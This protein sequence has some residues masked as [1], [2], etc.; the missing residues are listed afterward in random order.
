[1]NSTPLKG[2]I[3]PLVTPF[4]EEEKIDKVSL[5][6]LVNYMITQEPDYLMA[7][8]LTG[9]GP[10]LNEHETLEVWDEIFTATNNRVAVIPAIISTRTKTAITL[11]KAAYAL[12]APAIMVA[13]IVPELYAARSESDVYQFYSDIA[14]ATP[15]PLILFNYPSLTSVDLTPDF[16]KRLS[17]IENIAYIKESTGD[18]RRVHAIQ[19]LCSS[20]F[21]V[22]CGNPNAAFES[23]ALGCDTWITGIM[24]VAPRSSKAMMDAI[25]ID[26]DLKT[27]KDIYYNQLLPIVDLI[28]SSNNP[29]GMIKAGLRARGV[30][31]GIP[32]KPGSDVLPEEQ[33]KI[34]QLVAAIVNAESKQ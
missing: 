6:N 20:D 15:L 33:N 14:A 22:I 27:A 31:V 28:E 1:M 34:N 13:P 7:T 16:V 29:T 23:I 10:L 24:N 25:I 32:R 4:D 19:R 3:I 21:K 12:G 26:N 9:E 17:E 30:N 11:A 2:I 5:N 8:A 18:S